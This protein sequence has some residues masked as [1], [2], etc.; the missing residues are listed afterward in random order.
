MR[1]FC[2]IRPRATIAAGQSS[3]RPTIFGAM[4]LTPWP[5]NSRTTDA[6]AAGEMGAWRGH[7]GPARTQASVPSELDVSERDSWREFPGGVGPASNSVRSHRVSSNVT[8]GEKIETDFIR[9][10]G[11]RFRPVPD[12][13]QELEQK[14]TRFGGLSESANN[15][16]RSTQNRSQ[17][18]CRSPHRL[19]WGKIFSS[20]SRTFA[21]I[22]RMR[23]RL[24]LGS[25]FDEIRHTI[26]DDHLPA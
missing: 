8:R 13:C 5:G 3:H 26:A 7:L 4:K 25:G 11:G 23:S 16:R 14:S 2:P 17:P 24:V 15:K 18:H 21:S 20:L 19:L 9:V 22:R 6:I 1:P 12:S 10:Y